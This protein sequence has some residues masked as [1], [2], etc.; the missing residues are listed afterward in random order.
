MRR[1]PIFPKGA[2]VK[3]GPG[4]GPL[5]GEVGTVEGRRNKTCFWVRFDSDPTRRRVCRGIWLR[6]AEEN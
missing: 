4:F 2:R 5:T 1:F 3:R 6:W